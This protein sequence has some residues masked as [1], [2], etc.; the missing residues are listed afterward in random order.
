VRGIDLNKL[1]GRDPHVMNAGL[2]APMLAGKTVLVTGAAGSIGSE[3]AAICAK[4]AGRLVCVDRNDNG[5]FALNRRL[6]GAGECVLADVADQSATYRV[7]A[8]HAPDVV[9]HCAAHKHVPLMQSHPAEAVLNNAFGTRNVLESCASLGINRF[10]YV[11]T[12]KA[13]HPQSVMGASKRLGELFVQ[14]HDSE[15]MARSIVRF[16]N[17]L[18]SSC[19]VL[20]IW[21]EQL[22]EGDTLTVTSEWMTRYFMSIPEAAALTL[23]AGA[24]TEAGKL[25]LYTLDMGKPVPVVDLARRFAEAMGRPDAKVAFTGIRPGERLTERLTAEHETTAWTRHPGVLAVE[26]TDAPPPDL[27]ERA[28]DMLAMARVGDSEGVRRALFE[29]VARREGV[30][31]CP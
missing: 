3:V 7:M 8:R 12:D 19:S 20:A 24:M 18:G 14:A 17:V 16:G 9:V 6:D 29:C 22:A 13:V 1:I 4:Y 26:G 2:V 23:A 27:G 30:A 25:G 5:L 11:S 15:Y 28:A 31:A 21:H 10:V